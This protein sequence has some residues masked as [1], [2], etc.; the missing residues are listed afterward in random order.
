V[1]HVKVNTV[2]SDQRLQIADGASRIY[3]I[4]GDPIAQVRSPG[5]FN[6][7]FRALGVNTVMVPLHVKPECFDNAMRGLKPVAN[8][9]G[10]IITAPY[11]IRAAAYADNI[12]P[13][14]QRI[15]AINAIRREPDG[16]W[17]ADI[18][19]GKGLVGGMRGA[20]IDPKGLS[21]MLI[22]AGGAGSA[23]AD[24]LA[25][26]GASSICIFDRG[27]PKA[28]KLAER[29]ARQHPDCA[30][31]AGPATIDGTDVLINATPTGMTPGD[32]L[33]VDLGNLR[34]GLFVVDIVPRPDATPL[35]A[36]ARQSGCRTMGA[37]PMVAGQADAL[38]RFFRITTA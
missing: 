29:L 12:L 31:S 2:M 17:S 19:D 14:A 15:G 33:P 25:E 26:T 28:Q 11:K 27:L 3:G 6:E 38:L 20:G 30:V 4:I 5:F 24:A 22:G 13:A 1:S 34:S 16:T 23:I 7:K 10:L 37:Q 8:L 36:L 21:F 35:L 18:F 32:G 9:D